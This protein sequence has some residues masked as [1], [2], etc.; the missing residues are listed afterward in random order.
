MDEVSLAVRFE[1]TKLPHQDA[2]HKRNMK[3]E[4]GSLEE[5]VAFISC[6]MVVSRVM[7]M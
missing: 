1:K 5:R 3:P 6:S 7:D 4:R 2:I